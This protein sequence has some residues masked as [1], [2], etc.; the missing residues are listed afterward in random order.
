MEKSGRIELEQIT[1]LLADLGIL[2]ISNGANSGRAKRNL[3]R[4]AEAYNYKVQPFF[5]HSAII[6]TV[7]D[8]YSGRNK[9]IV[10][11]LI[12]HHVNYTKVSEVSILSWEISKDQPSAEYIKDEIKRI[13]SLDS[14]PE[15]VK[16]T[17]IAVASASLSQMFDGVFYE[18]LIT[19]LATV[20]GFFARKLLLTH[21]YNTYISWLFAAFISTTVVNIFR[22]F[23]VEHYH[24]ALTACVL[25]LIPGAPLINGF[26]DIL[27]NHI[28][29][30]WARAAM[31]FMMVFMI[32]VGF[33]LSLFLFGY[34]GAV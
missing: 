13:S 30:G 11:N 10:R 4:I 22:K 9:T 17:M 3:T 6:I 32:A 24:A 23:G 18:F 1:G 5:S 19:F 33:Y 14:Y 21:N 29:S 27:E 16:F 12:H 31:G 2:L 20:V 25:W 8:G 7:I 26:L 15:W 28:V 34:G